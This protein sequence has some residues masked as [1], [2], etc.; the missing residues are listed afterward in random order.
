MKNANGF[1]FV[2]TSSR[3][4][5]DSPA[6]VDKLKQLYKHYLDLET[7]KT[8][9]NK[10]ICLLRAQTEAMKVREAKEAIQSMISSERIYQDMKIAL[11]YQE[12]Y[13]FIEMQLISDSMK[14]S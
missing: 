1:V 12:R 2:K 8:D 14:I 13:N 6:T 7:E 4:A 5:K 3:S 9:N 11:M 10:I